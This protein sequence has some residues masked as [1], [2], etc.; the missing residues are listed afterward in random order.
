MLATSIPSDLVHELVQLYQHD[1]AE[2][3]RV[4]AQVMASAAAREGIAELRN[5]GYVEEDSRGIVRLT[6][7]GYRT[8]QRELAVKTASGT[9]KQSATT[10]PAWA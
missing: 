3:F 1:P 10:L 5:N 6:T 7:R 2:F 8:F 9:N 4:P